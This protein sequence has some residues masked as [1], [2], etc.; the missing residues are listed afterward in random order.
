[1]VQFYRAPVAVACIGRELAPAEIGCALTHLRLY[2]RMMAQGI[3]LALILED[4]AVIHPVCGE[5][6]IFSQS[7]IRHTQA[8]TVRQ[9]RVRAKRKC[10][11]PLHVR[12]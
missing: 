10:H 4:D 6:L 7:T 9:F 5:M 11:Y 8:A 12:S 2:E 1:V 3:D